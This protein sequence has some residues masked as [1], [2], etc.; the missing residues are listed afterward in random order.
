MIYDGVTFV[1]AENVI[2][3]DVRGTLIDKDG[4]Y[5]GEFHKGVACGK[6]RYIA[7]N[8]KAI[9]KGIWEN[10][11][12]KKGTIQNAAFKFKGAFNVSGVA[13]GMGHVQFK[14]SKSTYDG[15]VKDGKYHS[16]N[17]R[18]K[19]QTNQYHYQG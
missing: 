9:F 15:G 5:E 4:I 18:A 1:T 14:K 17:K 10:G 2:L 19:Y 8:T 6:G 12:M 7:K 13:E 11:I 3:P 16:Q